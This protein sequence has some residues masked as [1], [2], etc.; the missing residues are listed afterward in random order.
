[1]QNYFNAKAQSGKG[2]RALNRIGGENEL[3]RLVLSFVRPLS[4]KFG[5]RFFAALPL[6]GFALNPTVLSL[7]NETCQSQTHQFN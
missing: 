7:L 6:Y 1:M 4:S 2:A 3:H 5:N